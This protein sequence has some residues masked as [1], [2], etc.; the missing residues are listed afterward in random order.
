MKINVP[1]RRKD[2]EIE[3]SPCIVEKAVELPSELFE[4]FS[5]NLLNDYDFI[6]ENIDCMYQDKDG[7]NHCLLVLGEG[8]EDGIL[9][10]SEGSAYARYSAFVPN[11]RQ[12]WRQEQKYEPALQD[13]CDRMQTAMN[14]IIRTAPLHQ[15]NEMLRIPLSDFNSSPG[16]YP[17]D[18][19]L[20]YEM[21]N[22]RSEFDSVELF[23]DEI[24][25]QLNPKY[26]PA[27]KEQ[28]LEN[29]SDPVLSM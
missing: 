6:L 24:V 26:L 2:T 11:A 10:E 4:H 18:A 29:H 21:L 9:V 3:I 7:M 27:E 15:Q 20:L 28:D 16:E 12:L 23:E 25:A 13:F 19:V 14:E 22:G 5:E 1:F 8:Q 17:L